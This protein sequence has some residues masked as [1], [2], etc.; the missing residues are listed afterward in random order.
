[1]FS[2]VY[3]NR[4]FTNQQNSKPTNHTFLFFQYSSTCFLILTISHVVFTLICRTFLHFSTC[5]FTCPHVPIFGHKRF[6][7]YITY[8]YLDKYR[9][10]I[11]I[12]IATKRYIYIYIYRYNRYESL[13][14]VNLIIRTYL[15]SLHM[16]FHLV[17]DIK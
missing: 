3:C 2:N 13:T 17:I 10:V 9:Y 5:L 15:K 4:Y 7:L 1:M 11:Y 12:Y 8:V 14:H 16:H 6:R